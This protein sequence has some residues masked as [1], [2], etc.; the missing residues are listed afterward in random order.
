MA[1]KPRRSAPGALRRVRWLRLAG[2]A[3]LLV[4]LWLGWELYA[5][6]DV[7]PLAQRTP[8]QSSMMRARVAEAADAGR[9]ATLRHRFVPLSKIS[10]TLQKAVILAEDGR[11]WQHEGIDWGETRKAVAQAFDEGRLGRGASTITQQLAKNLYL[12]EGRSLTRKAKE[13]LL[14]DRLEAAL[15]KRRILELYL[16][17]AEWGPGVFGIEMAA[18]V[19][20]RKSA[21]DLDAGESAVLVAML[22]APRQRD[23][24]KPSRNLIRRSY[25]I[26]ELM[27]RVGVAPRRELRARVAALVGPEPSGPLAKQ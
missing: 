25:R 9:P 16:N 23:P 8:T 19:H 21:A 22:P 18:R 5:L 27:A 4:A 24:A 12:S 26:A 11:F 3:G 13:W 20:L 15:T 17:F 6:P 10:P 2:L 1:P 14:A 7:A